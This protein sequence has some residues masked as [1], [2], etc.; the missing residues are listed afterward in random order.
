MK[1]VFHY[2]E[3]ADGGLD[4]RKVR[5]CI[6]GCFQIFSYDETFAPMPQLKSF[7]MFFVLCTI[8][9][10]ETSQFD[11]SGAFLNSPLQYEI[12]VKLPKGYKGFGNYTHGIL[13]KSMYGLKQAARD[14]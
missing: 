11:V 12:W 10:L 8:L 5:T 3:L 9:N 6:R 2:K 14:W 13:R 7:R 1:E 4:K